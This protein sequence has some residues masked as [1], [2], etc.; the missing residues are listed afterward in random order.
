[1]KKILS[2]EA[3]RSWVKAEQPSLL[4]MCGAGDIDAQVRKK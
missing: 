4:V 1:M 3:M 2:K